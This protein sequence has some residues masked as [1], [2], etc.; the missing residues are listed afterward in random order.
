MTEEVPSKVNNTQGILRANG[1]RVRIV[2][3]LSRATDDT[4]AT[5]TID[6]KVAPSA[7]FKIAALKNLSTHHRELETFLKPL[8]ERFGLSLARVFSNN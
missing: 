8:V 3:L 4:T 5:T 6:P 1:K 2:D 7:S